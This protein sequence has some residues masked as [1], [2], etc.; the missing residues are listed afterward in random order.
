MKDIFVLTADTDAQAVMNSAL[1]RYQ[2]LGIRK[3]A[4]DV[5]RNPMRDWFPHV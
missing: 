2:S 3:I 5:D 4:Y 1:S